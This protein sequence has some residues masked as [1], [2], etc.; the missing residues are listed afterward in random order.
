MSIFLTDAAQQEFDA[1]VKHAYQGMALLN[2]TTRVRRNVVGNQA[3]FRLMGKGI[4]KQKASAADVI[5]MNVTHANKTATLGNWHAAEYTDIFDQQEVNF[6]EKTELAKAVAAA[7]G[8][9]SDQILIDE[10]FAVGAVANVA[11]VDTDV[12]G[13]GSGFNLDKMLRLSKLM[14][15]KGVPKDGRRHL[16]VTARALEQALLVS[17][18]SS[19]D[20]NA[21]RA[22][23]GGDIN[24]Y[25]GFMWHV[26]DD[27]T[28]AGREGGLP[29]VSAGLRQGWAWHEEAA[30]FASGIEFRTE[31]NYVPTKTAWLVNGIFK[32]GSVAIDVD[33]IYGVQYTE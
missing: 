8:R 3:K 19:A 6:D 11:S 29:L 9:R 24:R 5:P 28:A 22:L 23:M 26:F 14:D 20:Y 30:G 33:G 21:M 25:G 7:M 27:R 1:E 32:A 18:F 13:V 16:A 15:D 10:A 12:G 4:A 17:Q 31:I 2:G